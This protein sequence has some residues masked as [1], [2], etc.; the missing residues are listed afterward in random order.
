MMPIHLCT[1]RNIGQM[2]HRVPTDPLGD[3]YHVGKAF[4]KWPAPHSMHPDDNTCTGCHR[5]GN[6]YSCKEDPDKDFIRSAAGRK[7]ILGGNDVANSYPGSHWMPVDNF[8]SQAFWNIANKVSVDELL[9]CCGDPDNK[10]GFCDI[11]RI[12]LEPE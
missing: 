6:Q 2:W 12:S 4:E 9:A 11:Q 7:H 1:A 3:Y 8:H 5:I 10:L